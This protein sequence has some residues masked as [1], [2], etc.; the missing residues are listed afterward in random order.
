[1]KKQIKKTIIQV[2]ENSQGIQSIDLVCRPE[3][4]KY[5]A[6]VDLSLV[7][8]ELTKEGKIVR[9][10]CFLPKMYRRT[11]FYFPQGTKVV[12]S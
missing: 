7:L 11:V 4:A 9:L 2:I 10:E 3:I 8:Q 5:C 1:M 6:E 12:C